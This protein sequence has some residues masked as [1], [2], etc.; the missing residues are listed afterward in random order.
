MYERS[1]SIDCTT[2]WA[3]HM[4]RPECFAH[5]LKNGIFSEEEISQIPFDQNQTP[6]SYIE[7]FH[8]E[9]LPARL[10]RQLFDPSLTEDSLY[11]K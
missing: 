10:V 11:R 4:A 6:E 9:D 7:R 2:I 3:D 1:T 8:L 5:A